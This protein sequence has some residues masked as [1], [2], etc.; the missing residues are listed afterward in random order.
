MNLAGRGN[1]FL[2]NKLVVDLSTN[3]EQ[4]ESFF[5]LGT[6]DKRAIVKGLKAGQPYGLEI[7]I[8]TSDFAAR[9]SPFICWGGI[10]LGGARQFDGDEAI[11]EAATLA[12]NS[13]GA[14]NS[15][16]ILVQN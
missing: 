13:D 10:R 5:G 6:V 1:L 2:D 11:E 9:G 14:L 7:R 8:S 15:R 12:K 16:N 4:G 3:P